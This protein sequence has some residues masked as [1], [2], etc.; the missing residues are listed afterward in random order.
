MPRAA[1]HHSV[2]GLIGCDWLSVGGINVRTYI[3]VGGNSRAQMSYESMQHA[4]GTVNAVITTPFSQDTTTVQY[5][6]L[7]DNVAS[8]ESAGVRLFI[9]VGG[10]SEYDSLTTEE[11]IGVVERTVESVGSES[12]VVAGA[13]G[14]PAYVQDLLNSYA[15][16]GADGA[17]VM[18]PRT[19]S[20]IHEEGLIEYYRGIAKATDLGL[21]LYHRGDDRLTN[22][23]ITEL[24][25]I[26]NVVA[27]KWAIDDIV[28]FRTAV[29]AAPED[30]ATWVNG[31]AEEY[32]VPFCA[33]GATGFTSGIVNFVPQAS[34]ALHEALTAEEWDRAKQIRELLRPLQT[35]R[36]GTGEDNTISGANS[37]PLLK[38]GQEVAGLY[39][40]PLRPPAQELSAEDKRTVEA[41]YEAIQAASF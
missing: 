6:K 16:V 12:T 18:F 9:P 38:Y 2:T 17:M 41:T 15:A 13:G 21:M 33:E 7:A 34:L 39:G 25:D 37:A 14:S 24:V 20:S 30:A 1:R 28:A 10:V 35:L 23:V 19:H 40:G 31:L 27:I 11:R 22:R 26:P 8:L 3:I 5:D 4:F 32:T 29:E 36:G